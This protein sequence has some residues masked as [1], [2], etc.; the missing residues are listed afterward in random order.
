MKKTRIT[1]D[2]ELVET[3]RRLGRHA[4]HDEAAGA[5]LR[6]YVE[7]RDQLKILPLFGTIA[8]DPGYDYKLERKRLRGALS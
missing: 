8:Y 4:S 2:S 5:A 7:R 1:V 6:E 3:A